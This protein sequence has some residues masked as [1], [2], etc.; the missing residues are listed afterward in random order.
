MKIGDLVKCRDMF[1]LV[2]SKGRKRGWIILL[3]DGRVWP[4]Y[5]RDLEMINESR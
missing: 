2:I 5:S 3:E 4:I 1:G